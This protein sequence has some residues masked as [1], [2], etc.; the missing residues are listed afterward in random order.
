MIDRSAIRIGVVIVV[1]S[2]FSARPARGQVSVDSAPVIKTISAAWS[3][4]QAAIR[5]ARLGWQEQKTVVEVRDVL[6]SSPSDG[7]GNDVATDGLV[8]R[9]MRRSPV[10]V[11][12]KQAGTLC[13]DGD[14]FAF[15]YDA[16]GLEQLSPSGITIPS[17]FKVV[18]TESEYLRYSDRQAVLSMPAAG[19]TASLTLKRPDRCRE[20]QYPDVYPLVLALRPLMRSVSFVDLSHYRPLPTGG[21]VGEA[22]CLILEPA[23]DRAEAVSLWVD[24]LRDYV[25]RRAIVSFDGR[26]CSQL[27]IDYSAD[28]VAGWLP[29]EWSW[30]HLNLKGDLDLALRASLDNRSINMPLSPAEFALEEPAGAQVTDLRSGSPVVRWIG[31]REPVDAPSDWRKRLVVL[32]NIVV[33]LV[34]TWLVA[35][36]RFSLWSWKR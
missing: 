33:A 12:Y 10:V 27:D 31:G 9:P 19:P 35:T 32:G 6:S 7:P 8:S 26:E 5:T 13:L 16:K 14:R 18:H 20:A 1:L 29:K 25:I 3:K 36:R 24:P 34:V 4:R 28:P 11:R 17:R 22:P 30:V 23:D 2:A 21:V 15:T